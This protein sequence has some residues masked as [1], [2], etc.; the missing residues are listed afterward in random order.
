MDMGDLRGAGTWMEWE[1]PSEQVAPRAGP[2]GDLGE[3]ACL[4]AGD[5][6]KCG[7]PECVSGVGERKA[8]CC[9]GCG[10]LCKHLVGIYWCS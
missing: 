4:E 5:I 2:S 1:V 7:R 9:Y 3:D 8:S 10:V 6:P